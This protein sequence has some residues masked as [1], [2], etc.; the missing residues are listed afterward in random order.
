ML[1]GAGMVDKVVGLEV[2]NPL[3][4]VVVECGEA[5]AAEKGRRHW[6]PV[7]FGHHKAEGMRQLCSFKS[8]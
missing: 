5:F 2:A 6:Q 1:F 8:I 7:A 4:L 3:A